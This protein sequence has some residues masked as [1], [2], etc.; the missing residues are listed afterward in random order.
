MLRGY[1]RKER[2]DMMMS[3]AVVPLGVSVIAACKRKLAC[4]WAHSCAVPKTLR[5]LPSFPYNLCESVKGNLWVCPLQC[6][7]LFTGPLLSSVIAHRDYV[8]SHLHKDN[9]KAI[10]SGCKTMSVHPD[11]CMSALNQLPPFTCPFVLFFRACT[12]PSL[13]RKGACVFFMPTTN[14]WAQPLTHYVTL[15]GTAINTLHYAHCPRL[16]SSSIPTP[17]QIVIS[18]H[19]T[20]D[21]HVSFHPLF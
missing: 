3:R 13:L 9:N 18:P 5:M 11:L 15:L 14:C 20:L 7:Y 17:H 12:L 6:P 19:A 21:A 8:Q 4:S 2:Q 16:C 10:L 1:K